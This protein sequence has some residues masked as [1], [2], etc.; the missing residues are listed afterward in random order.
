MVHYVVTYS[1]YISALTKNKVRFMCTVVYPLLILVLSRNTRSHYICAV[2]YPLFVWVF[3]RQTSSLPICCKL[4]YPLFLWVFSRNKRFT[5]YV[6]YITASTIY[7]SVLSKSKFTA[8][9]LYDICHEMCFAKQSSHWLK[10]RE[11]MSEVSSS[12]YNF[13]F[14]YFV[15]TYILLQCAKI[16]HDMYFW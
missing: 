1:F 16:P 10:R 13:V 15:L 12:S 14:F 3:S 7:M 6:L 9:V 2:L 4:L 11:E 8:Y 5:T